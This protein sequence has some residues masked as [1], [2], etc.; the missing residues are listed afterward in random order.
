MKNEWISVAILMDGCRLGRQSA[1]CRPALW[2]WA[3][4]LTAAGAIEAAAQSGVRHLTLIPTDTF[5]MDRSDEAS[6]VLFQFLRSH[7]ETFRHL[8]LRFSA[9]GELSCLPAQLFKTSCTQCIGVIPRAWHGAV[10]LLGCSGRRDLLRVA[11][12]LAAEVKAGCQPSHLT[13]TDSAAPGHREPTA[14]RSHCVHGGEAK[15]RPTHSPLSPRM[16]S[17]HLRTACGRTFTAEDLQHALA[18]FGY[19]E[20]R[21]ARL[22]HRSKVRRPGKLRLFRSHAFRASQSSVVVPGV[23]AKLPCPGKPAP[24][25]IVTQSPFW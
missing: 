13:G 5:P 16:L 19:R 25:S 11:K 15:T 12:E 1:G 14:G 18:D 10:A 7:G 23:L 6:T 21:L 4:A 22:Q 2:L 9:H 20:R 3:S 17:L 24:P 8:S